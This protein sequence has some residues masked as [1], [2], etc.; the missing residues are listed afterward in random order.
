MEN[1]LQDAGSKITPEGLVTWMQKIED[2]VEHLTKIVELQL[3]NHN[4]GNEFEFKGLHEVTKDLGQK[5][6]ETSMKL[7]AVHKRVDR[8]ETQT[9]RVLAKYADRIVTLIVGAGV[10]AVLYY[11]IGVV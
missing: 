3:E 7:D 10:S 11:L 5:Y 9:G 6:S 1:L 8:L 2:S 4:K